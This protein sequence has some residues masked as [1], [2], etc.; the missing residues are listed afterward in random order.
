MSGIRRRRTSRGIDLVVDA[1]VVVTVVV[2]VVAVVVVV[3]MKIFRPS[4]I[5]FCA[6]TVI[7][8]PVFYW[9]DRDSNS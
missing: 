1:D 2:V 3:F 4:G 9:G 6:R 7:L 5:K 8:L